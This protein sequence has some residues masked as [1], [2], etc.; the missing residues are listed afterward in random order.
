MPVVI[1]ANML[2]LIQIHELAMV[3]QRL[4]NASGHISQYVRTN[5]N[6]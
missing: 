2:E 3:N 1:L 5:T 4:F 6:T